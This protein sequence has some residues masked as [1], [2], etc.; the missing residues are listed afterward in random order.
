MVRVSRLF[1]CKIELCWSYVKRMGNTQQTVALRLK[2]GDL[3][4]KCYWC[5]GR[6]MWSL[7]GLILLFRDGMATVML[8]T[9]LWP[10][11]YVLLFIVSFKNKLASLYMTYV[12]ICAWGYIISVGLANL[13]LL[14]SIA[15]CKEVLFKVLINLLH[16]TGYVM[17]HQLSIQQM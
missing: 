1:A 3:S 13:M 7:T 4:W 12:H 16:S 11:C 17:H 9:I 2:P 10:F 6:F 8:C 14:I 15:Y 5:A